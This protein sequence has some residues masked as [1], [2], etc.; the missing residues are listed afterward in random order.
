MK[1]YLKLLITL[2]LSALKLKDKYP[3]NLGYTR[4]D[5]ERP[6]KLKLFSLAEWREIKRTSG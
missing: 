2:S 3:M 4:G 6:L 1:Q 5:R